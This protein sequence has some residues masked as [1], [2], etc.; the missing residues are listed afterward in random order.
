MLHP[1]HTSYAGGSS[2]DIGDWAVSA[3]IVRQIKDGWT[4]HRQVPTFVLMGCTGN[5]ARR[6]ATEILSVVADPHELYLVMSRDH[7]ARTVT[8]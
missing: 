2:H 5:D 8:L 3:Q 7:Y 4:S 1:T 6:K